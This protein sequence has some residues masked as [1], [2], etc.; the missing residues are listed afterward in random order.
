MLY[1]RLSQP[2][3][4]FSYQFACFCHLI[5]QIPLICHHLSQ[6]SHHTGR[7]HLYICVPGHDSRPR[8]LFQNF[9]PEEVESPLC[10]SSDKKASRQLLTNPAF[11]NMFKAFVKEWLELRPIDQR[12]LLGKP[13]QLPLSLELCY[14]TNSIS[15]STQV[16]TSWL[17]HSFLCKLNLFQLQR[18][19]IRCKTMPGIHEITT[20]HLCHANFLCPRKVSQ[21]LL[22]FV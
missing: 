1:Y 6:V 15:H 13:L 21:Y 20:I 19:Q 11:C 10:S 7:I 3:T 16:C 2:A 4:L 12:K 8:P 9:L 18:L 17:W 14:L 5:L 22:K